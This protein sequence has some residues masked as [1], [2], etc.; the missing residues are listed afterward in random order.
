MITLKAAYQKDMLNRESEYLALAQLLLINQNPY[1]AANV[2]VSG[3]NKIV[4]YTE[5]TK[6]KV[7][8]KK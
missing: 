2:L 1:W 4:T 6:D 5:T 8:G 7:T 3:Q